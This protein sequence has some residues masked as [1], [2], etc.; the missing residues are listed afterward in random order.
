MN[1][2]GRFTWPDGR[3]YHGEYFNDKKHGTGSFIWSDGKRY[4]GTW[5]NGKQHGE[6]QF[7]IKNSVVGKRGIWNNGKRKEW[8]DF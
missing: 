1:G 4:S 6:G 2:F 3:I 8:L 7:F 5:V